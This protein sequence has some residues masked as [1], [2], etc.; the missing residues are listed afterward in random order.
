MKINK[1]INNY[2]HI[3]TVVLSLI[4]IG[5][6]AYY[7]YCDAACSYLKGDILGLDLKYV[8]IAFMTMIIVFATFKQTDFVR[9]LLATDRL[10]FGST[11]VC[12]SGAK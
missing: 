2:R 9:V 6:I 5:I 1:D 10:G 12:L 7:D 11:P 4:G 8:G 3:V